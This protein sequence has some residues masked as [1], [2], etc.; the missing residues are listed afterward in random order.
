VNTTVTAIVAIVLYLLAGTI[1][2]MRLFGGRDA[3]HPLMRLNR[4]WILLVASAAIAIHATLLY[5]GIFGAATGAL[6]FGFFNAASLM[7]WLIA[8]LITVGAFSKPVDNLSVVVLPGA[9]LAVALE[10]IFPST[11]ILL[12]AD[13]AELRYHIVIS[14]MAYSTLSIAALQSVLLAIQHKY[15]RA[16]HPGGFIRA[17]PPLETM[18]SLLFQMI[19][20]GFAF[21]SLSL[22]TGLPQIEDMFAQHQVHK[23]VLSIVAWCVFAVLLWGRWRFGWRGRTAVRWA[24]GGFVVLL[25]A[26]FGVKLVKELLLG[27]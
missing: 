3:D 11:H 9:A 1:L 2:G 21:L 15:L 19:G 25:L 18:E 12:A 24:L 23:T 22:L 16:K 14:I 6:N 13:A 4:T 7:T 10:Q 26:Y 27:L 5:Q 8:T 20:V 17:F